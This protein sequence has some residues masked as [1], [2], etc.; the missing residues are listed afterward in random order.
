[1]WLGDVPGVQVVRGVAEQPRIHAS[2]TNAEV[3]QEGN[4]EVIDV[5]SVVT[6]GRNRPLVVPPVLHNH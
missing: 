2:R 1:M 5:V 3:I 6:V 4:G